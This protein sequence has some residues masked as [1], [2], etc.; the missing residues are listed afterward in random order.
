MIYVRYLTAVVLCMHA[1]LG[2]CWHHAHACTAAPPAKD[3]VTLAHREH[4]HSACCHHSPVSC[5]PISSSDPC[6][7]SDH[8]HE[9]QGDRCVYVRAEATQIP[10]LEF[11]GDASEFGQ[12]PRQQAVVGGGDVSWAPAKGGLGVARLR[13]HLLHHILLI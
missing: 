9:C 4:S 10:P 5:N 11:L 8:R 6:D 13:L 12:L 3:A 1:L 7:D 2:C